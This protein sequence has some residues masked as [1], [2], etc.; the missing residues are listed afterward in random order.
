ML[1]GN[2]CRPG[3]NHPSSQHAGASRAEAVSS[4]NPGIAATCPLPDQLPRPRHEALT[5]PEP[6]GLQNP[7][8]SL[9]VPVHAQPHPLPT[10]GM[11]ATRIQTVFTLII[12]KIKSSEQH[13][14]CRFLTICICNKKP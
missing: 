6:D 13:D 3:A 9:H 11:P 7:G 2:R 5:A 1:P 10:P 14:T 4:Q 8:E 12:K